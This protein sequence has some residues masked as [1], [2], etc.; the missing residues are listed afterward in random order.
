MVLEVAVNGQADVIVTFNTKD[1]KT[2]I[3]KFNLELMLPNQYLK[4][5]QNGN[6]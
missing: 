3:H 5:I 1:F 6:T 2:S 4:V